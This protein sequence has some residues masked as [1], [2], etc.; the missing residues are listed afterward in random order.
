MTPKNRSSKETK[1]DNPLNPEGTDEGET[2]KSKPPTPAEKT[3]SKVT[4]NH[5]EDDLL[6]RA[7]GFLARTYMEGPLEDIDRMDD[8]FNEALRQYLPK[9]EKKYNGGE[10][11]QKP[12]QLPRGRKPKAG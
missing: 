12:R 4:I 3:T 8:L 7:R 5:I 11:F 6:G 10:P 1:I 9:L 2:S